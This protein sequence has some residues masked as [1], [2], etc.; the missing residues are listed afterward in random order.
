MLKK[1]G[2]L[3]G[4]CFALGLFSFAGG[5]PAKGKALYGTCIAC[6]GMSGEGQKNLNAPAL[7]GQSE[8]YLERQLKNYKTGVRGSD[9]KDT[10]GMQMRPMAMILPNDQA[11]ADVSAY[12]ATFKLASPKTTLSGGDAAKGKAAYMICATCHG[13]DGAGN[14]ALNAP[15][16]QGQHDW[17]LARQLETFKAG[18]R[19]S[20]PKDTYGMQMKPMTMSLNE[21]SIKDV[22][23]YITTLK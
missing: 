16:L 17:Y 14:K 12:I 5:D 19:G 13:P 1:F 15:T 6:H 7:A 22:V 8:W 3:L 4:C 9:P 18:I 2:L 11:I 21:Q 20:H 23:A 10:Y